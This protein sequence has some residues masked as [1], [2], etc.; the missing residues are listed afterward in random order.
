MSEKKEANPGL[1]N[2][3][4]HGFLNCDFKHCFSSF[5]FFY[6]NSDVLKLTTSN[7]WII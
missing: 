7:V 3:E 2:D 6:I 1:S 5:Y 4:L